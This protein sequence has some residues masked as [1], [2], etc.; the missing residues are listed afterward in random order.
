MREALIARVAG[1][2]QDA[3]LNAGDG[4][5]DAPTAPEMGAAMRAATLKLRA[6][7]MDVAGAHVDYGRL[8][9]SKAYARYRHE[10]A[11]RLRR[12][13]LA[14]LDS[15]EERLAFWIN[16]YNALVIDAVA[17]FGIQ[18]SVL[19]GRLGLFS[20]FRRAAYQVG[21]HRFSLNDI[22]HGILR[23]NRR[24]WAI[25]GTQFGPGD[26]RLAWRVTPLDPRIH[27]A[28]NCAS[29]SC[30]PIRVYSPDHIDAQLD[31]AARSFVAGDVRID[32][33]AGVIHL[34]AIFRWYAGDFGG[35]PG[36]LAF[37]ASH[38]PDQSLA[39]WLARH[40]QHGRLSYH[41]YDWGLNK[42]DPLAGR[43][44]HGGQGEG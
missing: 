7:H 34:S 36:V 40:G 11:P 21:G 22:E 27:F 41:E 15:R 25:P 1:F 13:D 17:M 12:L 24:H 31:L 19:E 14:T 10:L 33:T 28:L 18:N 6:E 26:P 43:C 16:L 29:L 32:P 30:P 35:R 2:S 38:L 9:Q 39:Q 23:G 5:E 42:S 20:F 8:R 3:A 37:V 44:E 4:G